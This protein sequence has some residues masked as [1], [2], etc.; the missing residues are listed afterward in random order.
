MVDQTITIRSRDR[1]LLVGRTGSGKTFAAEHLTRPLPRL[2][3]LDPKGTLGTWKL[4]P[5]DRDTRRRLKNGD[6]V[7]TRVVV[8]FGKDPDEIWDEALFEVYAG[9]NVTCYVDE[10]YGVVDPGSKPSRNLT[11]LWTRGRELGVGAWAA[12]QRPAWVPLFILSEAD[13][14]F[15]FRLSLDEDR[16]RMA[17]FLGPQAMNVI[18]EP[19]GVLYSK[20]EWETPVMI[21]RLPFGPNGRKQS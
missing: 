6:P 5:W 18:R 21:P 8:P 7:R 19:N 20:P 12:S 14:F 13:H 16:R 4:D 9:G 15:Q 1:V 3:V 10:V 17:A 11:G 2:V